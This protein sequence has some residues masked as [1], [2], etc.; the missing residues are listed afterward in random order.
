MVRERLGTPDVDVEDKGCQDGSLWL[1]DVVLGVE[2][3]SVCRYR[4]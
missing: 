3:C 1:R 2:T 4:W